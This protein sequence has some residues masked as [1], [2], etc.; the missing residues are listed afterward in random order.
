MKKT[1]TWLV[2]ALAALGLVSCARQDEQ[3]QKKL[4][5][6][7]TKVAGIEKKIN[8]P[9]F[10]RG[11]GPAARAGQ[12]QPGSPDPAGVYSIGV[13]GDPFE[14]ALHAQVTIVEAFEFA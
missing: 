10:G 4:D 6:L 9:G 7:L 13:D 14:G 2:A 3:T 5:D 8:E 12:Q 1:K 11:A